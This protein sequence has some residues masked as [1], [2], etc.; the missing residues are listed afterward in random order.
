MISSHFVVCTCT[1]RKMLVCDALC[2]G[3]GGRGVSMVL[4][5]CILGYSVLV[6]ETRL[7][8]WT[9]DN[10]RLYPGPDPEFSVR[11]RLGLAI[12]F[13]KLNGK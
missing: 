13:V 7:V 3:R 6:T 2:I 5:S 12:F 8:Y 10:N 1:L 9:D 4:A 11:S